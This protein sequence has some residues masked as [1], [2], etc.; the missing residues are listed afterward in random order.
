MT[1][2]AEAPVR[3]KPAKPVPVYPCALCGRPVSAVQAVYSR[4]THDRFH[5]SCI[6]KRGKP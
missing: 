4:W 3:R 5:P 2:W 6:E 1:S